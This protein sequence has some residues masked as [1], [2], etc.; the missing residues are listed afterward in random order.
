MNEMAVGA[1]V[2]E[3]VSGLW[4]WRYDATALGC[5]QSGGDQDVIDYLES[6]SPPSG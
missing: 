3:V 2:I 4:L 5:A 1:E 6:R